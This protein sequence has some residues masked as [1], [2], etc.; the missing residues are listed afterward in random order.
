MKKLIANRLRFLS[1]F[2]YIILNVLLLNAVDAKTGQELKDNFLHP[3]MDCRPHTYWWWPGNAVTAEEITWE[4]E[5]MKE[6]G[7]GGVLV[8]SAAPEV[9]E[10]GNITFLSNEHLDMLRNTVI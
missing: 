9:Y 8:T 4:L 7:L 10:K 3:P 2:I 6:K 5:Q 1:G